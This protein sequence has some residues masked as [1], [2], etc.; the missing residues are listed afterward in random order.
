L[1]DQKTTPK[2]YGAEAR[3]AK[4]RGLKWCPDCKRARR[5]ASF[6]PNA[7]R[8]D[9][10]QSTCRVCQ[11]ARIR[12]ASPRTRAW[13]SW[14][15]ARARCTDPAHPFWG[16]YGERGITMCDRWRD[17]FEM[18]LVDMGGR[19]EGLTLDRVNND[20]NYEPGNCRWASPAEQTANRR[21]RR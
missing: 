1:K 3:A 10:L 12:K 4:K 20:G 17:D 2:K 16:Y 21:P 11:R 6:S 19:P 15:H 5:R 13:G 9:G 14:Y 18:F 8:P 7:S